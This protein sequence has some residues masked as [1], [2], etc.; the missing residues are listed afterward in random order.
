VNLTS[1]TDLARDRRLAHVRNY[2]DARARARRTL[3]RGLFDYIDGGSDDEVTLERNVA[4]FRQLAFRPRM[5][6]RN[7]EPDLST[8]VGGIALSMPVL[9]APCGGMR[10]VH[11]D[12]DIAVAQAAA[13]QGLVHVATAAA[14]FTLEEIAAGTGPKWFQLYRFWSRDAMESLV[15]RA[16]K[17][18]YQAL[19]VTVDTTV[20]GNREKDFRNGFSYDL[21]INAR[22]AIRMAPQVAPRPFWLYHYWRDGMPFV[23]PNTQSMTAD[24]RAVPLTAMATSSSES[25]SPSWE[26]IAWVRDNW[27]GPLLIKGLLT[28]DDARRAADLGATGVVVSNH[29]GRQLD[30]APATISCLPEVVAA[31]GS[32]IEVLLDSGIRRGSDVVK[33][34]ALGAK[35]VLVGRPAV[36]GLA[37]GGH[38]GVERMLTIIR[39]ELVRTMRL[40]GARSVHELDPSWVTN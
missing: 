30:G 22:S 12:G 28:A 26:D 36:W 38:A 14:G 29:G 9:T 24:G 20:G 34:L 6:V 37:V 40:L 32:D 27:D 2:S 17:A 18:G 15:G 10:L 21:R 25:H 16:Q 1:L 8:T 3:P 13:Q 35:A 7:P 31:V 4:A 11:P 19:V 23:I 39:N 5:A 33:A